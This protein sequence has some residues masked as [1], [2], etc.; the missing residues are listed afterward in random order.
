MRKARQTATDPVLRHWIVRRAFGRTPG[1]PRFTAHRP[2]YLE[3]MLPL[4][5]ETPTAD[6]AELSPA[7]PESPI[8]LPLPGVTARVEPGGADDLYRRAFADEETAI[9][10]HRFAWL[11]LVAGRIDPAC[12]DV[13]WRAWCEGHGTPDDGPAWHPY[14]AAE[15]AINIVHFARRQGLPGPRAETLAVLAEHAPAIASG[16]E[17][18]GDHHTSNHLANNGRGLFVLGLALGLERAA[19]M[20]GRI[21]IE[22]ARRIF[23]PSGILREGSS[24]YHLLL[25][26]V[27]AEAWLAARRHGRPEAEALGQITE[28]TLAV[29]P[30]LMLPGGM[31]LV[32]DVSPDCPPEFLNGL[33]AGDEGWVGGL[34]SD[35]RTVFAELRDGVTPADADTLAADG[36]R[37][38][39]FGAW[40]G[41]WHA[42]PAGWSAMPGH[43]HQD[44]GGFEIH[45]GADVVFR[46]LG[47]GAYGESGDAAFYRSA[48]AHNT[49]VVDG[50]DPY[51]PNKPYYDDA[52]RSRIGGP[53]P[54]LQRYLNA[55]TLHHHGY[56]RLGGVGALSRR[57]SFS[58]SQMR[59]DDG[60]DGS[61]R[62][63]VSRRLHTTLAVER[64]ADGALFTGREARFRI[65]ADGPVTIEPATFWGAYGR[66]GPATAIDV[67]IAARLPW[68]GVLTVEVE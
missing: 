15:R 28:K 31:P 19:D 55:L 11:P 38:A 26:R 53:L 62:H 52:F 30:R 17:Y 1:E 32:G 23:S 27:Y 39:D 34:D 7:S 54:K 43:G 14:T 48:L 13:L 24:H 8:D 37:R 12:V 59:I 44:I 36:W 40:S 49:L 64:T 46:D 65:R 66:G 21:L 2:P 67:T 33:A 41:L 58:A 51:P 47:R 6:L 18:F 68:Q 56:A 63:C 5:G 29:I 61:G 42:P 35:E 50:R 9:A 45:H 10:V 4:T 25:T 22:E 20:G 3:G 57:W 60:V 16:L